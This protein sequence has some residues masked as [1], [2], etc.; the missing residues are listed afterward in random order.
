[1]GQALSQLLGTVKAGAKVW[2]SL[3]FV[4]CSLP[5]MSSVKRGKSCN[6]FS[7]LSGQRM[8]MV[9]AGVDLRNK[10]LFSNC[11]PVEVGSRRKQ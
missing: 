1:M 7:L 8:R 5:C 11:G 6:C 2:T 10:E 3:G 4:W 9:M